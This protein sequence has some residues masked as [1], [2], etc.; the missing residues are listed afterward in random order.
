MKIGQTDVRLLC[1]E[2]YMKRIM[3][4]TSMSAVN[5]RNSKR[6][7][8]RAAGENIWRKQNEALGVVKE[9]TSMQYRR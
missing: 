3:A 4:E 9:N 7:T 5:N 6:K 2:E 1:E 8:H